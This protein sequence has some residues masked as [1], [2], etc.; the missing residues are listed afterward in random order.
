M[1]TPDKEIIYRKVFIRS[2]NDL[3]TKEDEYY[4]HRKDNRLEYWNWYGANFNAN[5]MALIDWY[6]LPVELPTEEEIIDAVD[7]YST[8]FIAGAKAMRDGEIKHTEE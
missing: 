5:W 7:Y 1:T 2:V 3:P 6:L 8:G 4:V